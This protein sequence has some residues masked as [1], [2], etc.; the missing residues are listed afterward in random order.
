MRLRFIRP[1]VPFVP[2]IAAL[3]GCLIET[4]GGGEGGGA[5]PDPGSTAGAD[6]DG[7]AS[8][9]DPAGEDPPGDGAGSSAGYCAQGC[10]EAADCCEPGAPDCPGA[11]PYAWSCEDGACVNPGC[12]SDDECTFGGALPGWACF[13]IP[14]GPSRA[15]GL[16]AEPCSTHADCSMGMTCSG[17]S[18]AGAF[19]TM[20][21]TFRC[22]DDADCEGRGTCDPD[23]GCCVC[24]DS[25]QCTAP[26][27][28]TC[29]R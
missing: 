3:S 13:S 16:C 24:D 23:S 19:C 9:D 28:D 17:Q 21:A 27:F 4:S 25:S 7:E 8:G 20:E 29:S 14:I 18:P 2:F 5:G 10:T 15:M 11:F 22:D 26:G 12:S 1:L 6:E